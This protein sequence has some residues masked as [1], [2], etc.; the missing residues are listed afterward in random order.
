MEHPP[1][2]DWLMHYQN[3]LGWSHSPLKQ[4]NTK[5]VQDLSCA[6]SGS[7]DD[8]ERQQITPLVHDGV[9]F[10]S[11]NVDNKVQALNAKTGDLIWE[12]SLGATT[13]RR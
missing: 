12:N 9:M 3:Y 6:G 11:V 13:Y 1:A 4:I 2:S 8:G 7:L 10:I 5:N